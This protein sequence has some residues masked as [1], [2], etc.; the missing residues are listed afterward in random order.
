MTFLFVVML[1]QPDG[2]AAYDRI[3]WSGFA[4]PIA[5]LAAGALIAVT[6]FGVSRLPQSPNLVAPTLSAGNQRDVLASAH[7]AKLGNELFGKHLIS[8]ELV[9]TL[10]LVALAGAVV[11]VL[12]DKSRPES[13]E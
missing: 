11:F 7:M 13:E 8:V 9:G 6:A 10:L 2:H 4:K 3:S 12:Q 5:T 1:A